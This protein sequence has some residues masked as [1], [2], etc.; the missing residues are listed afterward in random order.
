[1]LAG[2]RVQLKAIIEMKRFLYFVLVLI[3][4]IWI[5]TSSIY[6]SARHYKLLELL[7]LLYA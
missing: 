6:F 3:A 5:Y 1:M 2:Q 7:G 4:R